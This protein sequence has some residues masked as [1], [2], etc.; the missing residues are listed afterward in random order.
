MTLFSLCEYV[1][2]VPSFKTSPGFSLCQSWNL[3]A[4]EATCYPYS[5]GLSLIIQQVII[6]VL[7]TIYQ[8]QVLQCCCLVVKSCSILY[9]SMDYIPPGSFFYGTSQARI[10]RQVSFPSPGDFHD[11]EVKPMPP[12]LTDGVFTTE[13][14][15]KS[16]LSHDLTSIHLLKKCILYIK[17]IS[18]TLRPSD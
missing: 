2:T 4:E 6:G 15:G 7:L 17:N 10:P 8:L 1:E 9:D 13:P 11:P 3:D 18:I 12:S 14:P 5:G 16:F